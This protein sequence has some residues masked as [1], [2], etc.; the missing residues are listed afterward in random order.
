MEN[1]K[2]TKDIGPLA[3]IKSQL[4]EMP[5]FTIWAIVLSMSVCMLARYKLAAF[6][7]AGLQFKLA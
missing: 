3:I 2:K 4:I 1:A 7:T 6:D 5:F